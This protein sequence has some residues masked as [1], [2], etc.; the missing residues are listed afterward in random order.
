VVVGLALSQRFLRRRIAH[1]RAALNRGSI[2]DAE[3][4]TVG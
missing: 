2:S 4:A 1:E 3:S